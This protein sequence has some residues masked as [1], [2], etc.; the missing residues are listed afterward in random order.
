VDNFVV[1]LQRYNGKIT[2]ILNGRHKTAGEE[3]ESKEGGIA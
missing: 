2:V 1:R 3:E